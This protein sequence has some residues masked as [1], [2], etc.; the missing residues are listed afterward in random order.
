MKGTCVANAVPLH[1]G[2][3][4]TKGTRASCAVPIGHGPSSATGT[5]ANSVVPLSRGINSATGG[6]VSNAAPLNHGKGACASSTAPPGHAS[7]NKDAATA[8][9]P[10]TRKCSPSPRSD[11]VATVGLRCG[12]ASSKT[13]TSGHEVAV[14]LR[15]GKANTTPSCLARLNPVFP[16]DSR[17]RSILFPIK[18]ESSRLAT[19][20]PSSKRADGT[21]P[22]RVG[23][24]W[25][26]TRSPLSKT[27]TGATSPDPS[28]RT[29]THVHQAA[30]LPVEQVEEPTLRDGPVVTPRPPARSAGRYTR[31]STEESHLSSSGSSLKPPAP[32]GAVKRLPAVI[33]QQAMGTRHEKP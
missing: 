13:P 20:F 5:R 26:P 24:I 7:R 12:K 28:S 4:S 6:R 9:R 18:E 17:G 30:S 11:R 29:L 1:P 2:P 19:S 21:E 10:L 16:R 27:H 22:P 8:R 31:R 33:R 14:G 23:P 15:C 32:S 25:P 3:I